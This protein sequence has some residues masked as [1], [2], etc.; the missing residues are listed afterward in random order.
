MTAYCD[1]NFYVRL[2]IEGEATAIATR[3]LE[4][5]RSAGAPPI[6]VTWL[7]QLELANA[8]P[9]IAFLARQGAAPRFSRESAAVAL[10]RFDDFLAEGIHFAFHALPVGDLTRVARELSSRHT[11]QHGFRAYDVAHVASALLLK[12]DTFWSFDAKASKLAKLEGLKTL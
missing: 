4:S 1:T 12:C 5:I 6:L 7:V 10:A 2:L 3:K 8:L 9:Q 11:A